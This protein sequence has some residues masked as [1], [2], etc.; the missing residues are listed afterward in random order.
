MTALHEDFDSKNDFATEDNFEPSPVQA[1]QELEQDCESQETGQEYDFVEK[2]DDDYY[3]P[4]SSELLLEPQQTSCCGHHISQEAIDRLTRERK[5]CPMCKEEDFT[6]Q[7]DKYFRRKVYQLKVRCPHKLY[8]C[9]WVGEL[10]N[11]YFHST[12]CLKRPWQC[13]YCDHETTFD[14]GTNEHI[15]NCTQYPLPCPNQ[16]GIGVILR[17]DAEKHLLVCPLQLVECEFASYGCEVKVPRR[18]LTRHMTEN[19]QHHLMSATLLNLRLTREL[20]QKMEEKDQ[21]I[22]E[23]K[24]QISNLDRKLTWEMGDLKSNLAERTDRG[25]ARPSQYPQVTR[26]NPSSRPARH[27]QQSERSFAGRRTQAS[28]IPRVT[29]GVTTRTVTLDDFSQQ[30]AKGGT[31]RWQSEVFKCRGYFFGLEIDTNGYGEGRN[32]HLSALLYSEPSV[33]DCT[34][35]WPAKVRV[36][37]EMLDQRELKHQQNTTSVTFGAPFRRT[38]KVLTSQFFPL[39]DLRYNAQT[40]TE[41]L[42]DDRITFK[43]SITIE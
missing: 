10:G 41:Y 36:H 43:V 39:N 24:K 23:L 12:T 28:A 19:A 8:G 26:E 11:L 32:S 27:Q 21:Q 30:Q 14:V 31:G 4:V 13:Q 40:G 33:T 17:C 15:S 3:C 20:H 7:T 18:D 5:P 29:G 42:K 16:C 37:L 1:S 2:P 25:R 9:E 35:I 6:A 22:A 34:L 38:S